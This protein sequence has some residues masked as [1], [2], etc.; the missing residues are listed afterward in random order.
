[1]NMVSSHSNF[2]SCKFAMQCIQWHSRWSIVPMKC[3]LQIF[4]AGLTGCALNCCFV[5]EQAMTAPLSACVWIP[6][7]NSSAR[8]RLTVTFTSGTLQETFAPPSKASTRARASSK[9]FLARAWRNCTLT[10]VEDC[11]HAER[12][13]HSRFASWTSLRISK[14]VPSRRASNLTGHVGCFY[15]V[16][17]WDENY[18]FLK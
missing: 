9:T 13:D 4:H 3:K 16:N 2:D 12:M 10:H 7:K 18:E 15:F 11:F 17:Y 14:A 1:M 6:P 8:A 5:L